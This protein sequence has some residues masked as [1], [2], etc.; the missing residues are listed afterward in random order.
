[1]T[2][3][4]YRRLSQ[5]WGCLRAFLYITKTVACFEYCSTHGVATFRHWFVL[6]LQWVLLFMFY[7]F[8]MNLGLNLTL[9][10]LLLFTTVDEKK[11]YPTCVV[12]TLEV[13]RKTTNLNSSRTFSSRL[14]VPVPVVFCCLLLSVSMIRFWKNQLVPIL[15]NTSQPAFAT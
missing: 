8:E 6:F 3:E 12:L 11:S 7:W 13:M 1:M 5:F 9:F 10:V 2:W 15:G 14:Q 4:S